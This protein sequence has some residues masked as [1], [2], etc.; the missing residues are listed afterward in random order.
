MDA[1]HPLVTPNV[2]PVRRTS[3]VPES[4]ALASVYARWL[5]VT[6]ESPDYLV[7]AQQDR[8][9]DRDPERS[10]GLEVHHKHELGGLLYR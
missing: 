2:M 8:F 4:A 6:P 3:S 10:G 7:G 5:D 9:R 1:R